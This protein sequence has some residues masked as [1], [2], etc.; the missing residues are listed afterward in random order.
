MWQPSVKLVLFCPMHLEFIILWADFHIRDPR[1]TETT[2]YSDH[3]LP[4]SKCWCMNSKLLF[5][6]LDIRLNYS[7]ALKTCSSTHEKLR[8]SALKSVA[9]RTQQKWKASICSFSYLC[10]FFARSPQ[11][12]FSPERRR[13]AYQFHVCCFLFHWTVTEARLNLVSA[14]ANLILTV[15]R[16][17]VFY[18]FTSV[19]TM[20]LSIVTAVAVV[21]FNDCALCTV[22]CEQCTRKH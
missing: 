10:V 18:S 9:K 13:N 22:R 19:S 12:K 8:A 15:P 5:V 20:I 17:C 21:S 6:A 4:A 2:T 1:S 11:M 7:F 14:I 3:C 16:V